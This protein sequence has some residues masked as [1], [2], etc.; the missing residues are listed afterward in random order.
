MGSLHLKGALIFDSNP[1]HAYTHP[2]RNSLSHLEVV[3][4]PIHVDGDTY[5][6]EYLSTLKQKQKYHLV[7]SDR[8][9]SYQAKSVG[10]SSISSSD[11]FTLLHDLSLEKESLRQEVKP[12]FESKKEIER[13]QKIFESL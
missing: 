12:L 13:L 8:E 10:I 5:I 1:L 9:L 11:F 6:L 4:A 3:Y 7:T 2:T